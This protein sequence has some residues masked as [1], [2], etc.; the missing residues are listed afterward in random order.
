MFPR[1]SSSR[2]EENRIR[3]FFGTATTPHGIA[4]AGTTATLYGLLPPGTR[5][6]LRATGRQGKNTVNAMRKME[7]QP[8]YRRGFKVTIKKEYIPPFLHISDYDGP[9]YIMDVLD[10]G[11]GYVTL[12]DKQIYGTDITQFQYGPTIMDDSIGTAEDVLD[13][14][15]WNGTGLVRTQESEFWNRKFDEFMQQERA[16]DQQVREMF[17]EG[18]SVS[19]SMSHKLYSMLNAHTQ[20]SSVTDDYFSEKPI[21]PWADIEYEPGARVA[22]IKTPL[23]ITVK[24]VKNA[25]VMD[26]TPT[27]HFSAY[28]QVLFVKYALFPGM[29][30]RMSLTLDD[31]TNLGALITATQDPVAANMAE[32]GGGGALPGGTFG[33]RKSRRNRR[34]AKKTRTKRTNK[35]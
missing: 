16:Y 17:P 7:Q 18:I 22:R 2:E 25:K 12:I 20:I 3:S 11:R 30:K 23:D 4:S 27:M 14:Y 6:A 33:G 29:N 10:N 24:V 13:K 26:I 21:I 35:K 32:G 1:I 31:A 15:E 9:L 34:K 8:K 19:T 28:S 5:S